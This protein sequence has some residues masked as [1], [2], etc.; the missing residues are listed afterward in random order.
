MP[1]GGRAS[2][3]ERYIEIH[4]YETRLVEGAGSLF[5]VGTPVDVQW[6]LPDFSPSCGL[7]TGDMLGWG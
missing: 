7:A 1:S 2:W 4:R 6:S 5:C 3:F